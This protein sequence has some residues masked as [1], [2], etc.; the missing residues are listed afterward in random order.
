MPKLNKIQRFNIILALGLVTV[1]S[2][3]FYFQ[4]QKRGYSE[5]NIGDNVRV[6]NNK[7]G[8]EFDKMHKDGKMYYFFKGPE[9]ESPD[10]ERY[11]YVIIIEN[12]IVI[13]KEIGKQL[14]RSD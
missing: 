11:V 9:I 8:N 5:V 13:K 3:I 4:T 12:G 6:L 14:K 10:H 7:M 2:V 1:L